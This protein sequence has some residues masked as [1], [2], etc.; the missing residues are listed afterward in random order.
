MLALPPSPIRSSA[1]AAATQD[2]PVVS[3]PDVI[4]ITDLWSSTD[5]EGL[6]LAARACRP[7][8]SDDSSFHSEDSEADESSDTSLTS[9]GTS[10]Y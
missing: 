3:P 2:P 7:C 8:A 1:D 6:V 5:D 9:K 4:D 10:S